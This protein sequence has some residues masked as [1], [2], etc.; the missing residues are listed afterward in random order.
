MRSF[1]FDRNSGQIFATFSSN[2]SLLQKFNK[3]C[4]N[5]TYQY[6]SPKEC[7]DGQYKDITQYLHHK[8]YVRIAPHFP[9]TMQL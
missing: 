3:I 2:F 5:I 1:P 6:E 4:L 8:I 7:F 9:N